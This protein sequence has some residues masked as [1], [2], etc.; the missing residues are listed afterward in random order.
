M[1][2]RSGELKYV[3]LTAAAGSDA[4]ML[5]FV[6][7]SSRLIERIRAALPSLQTR[8]TDL[9]VISVN[10]QPKPA[11]IVEG[12]EEIL[13]SAQACLPMR[14]DQIEM[15]LMP[16]G[17]FQTNTGVASELYRT[18]QRWA[19][20]LP[21]RSAL[22]LFCGVGGFALHLAQAGLSVR[23]WE[24]HPAAVEA[25]RRAARA[26]GSQAEFHC[27]SVD[28]LSLAGVKADLWLVNPPR[29]GLGSAL[30]EQI[31]AES[32]PFLLYS[33]CNPQSLRADLDALPEYRPLKARLFDMFPHTQ[34][35]EVM[36]LLA[37]PT[38]AL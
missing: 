28:E 12:A 9:A 17:F 8:L 7:R 29:R 10:L 24:V 25:A 11:A 26:S 20:A 5:R 16:G 13:L 34:H 22:D 1:Q 23:G 2:Q 36:L 21:I 33:S 15:Q 37:R 4:L 35:A 18:A 3:L 38:Q 31:R 6:L 19:A 14:F 27:A 32:P 30:I